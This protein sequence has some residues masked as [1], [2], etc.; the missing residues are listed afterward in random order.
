MDKSAKNYEIQK[1]EKS[2]N[3]LKFSEELTVR[4]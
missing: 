3:K 1:R 2:L 4:E